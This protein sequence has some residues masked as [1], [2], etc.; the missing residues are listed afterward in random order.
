LKYLQSVV[1]MTLVVVLSASSAY[2]AANLS[3]VRAI[4]DALQK[5]LDGRREQAMELSKA[6]DGSALVVMQLKSMRGHSQIDPRKVV[7]LKNSFDRMAGDARLIRTDI[8]SKVARLSKFNRRI[9]KRFPKRRAE[10]KAFFKQTIE[11]RNVT[12]RFC[13]AVERGAP[14]RANDLK[15]MLKKGFGNYLANNPQPPA[16]SS[17]PI[18]QSPEPTY[19]P[20]TP[21][22]PVAASGT[23]DEELD[24]FFG[25]SDAMP[26]MMVEQ[27]PPQAA[28]P[29]PT[30]VPQPPQAAVPDP[31]P[32]P[33]T[34][35]P[36]KVAVPTP[37]QA[38]VPDPTP[39]PP[40]AA[41]PDPT[42]KPAAP[43]PADDGDDF[44]DAFSDEDF[45]NESRAP[46]PPNAEQLVQ[47]PHKFKTFA[48]TIEDEFRRNGIVER[49]GARS[50]AP[51]HAE[52][53][54]RAHGLANGLYALLPAP[55]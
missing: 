23:T 49:V 33:A 51:S 21:V 35:Q 38:A 26:P 43:V 32:T 4:L 5:Q 11:V 18:A 15:K 45:L 42:P 52:R 25:S 41:V 2:A 40:Q 37:P 7:E 28:I 14:R 36:P 29:D 22:A 34:P 13:K 20:A 47:R 1:V 48:A 54:S 3:Q 30:P 12:V 10:F 17:A 9:S 24:R 50:I 39:T 16:R 27:E 55:W 46:L 8:F 31:I 6:Y 53:T 19:A 44:G